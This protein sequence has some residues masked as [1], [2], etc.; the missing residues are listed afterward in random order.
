MGKDGDHICVIDT[1]RISEKVVADNGYTPDP[2][3]RMS[4]GIRTPDGG[5]GDS[6]SWTTSQLSGTSG[7]SFKWRITNQN[8]IMNIVHDKIVVLDSNDLSCDDL[9]SK[10]AAFPYVFYD[11]GG[12]LQQVKA[13]HGV[14]SLPNSQDQEP[15]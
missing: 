3:E 7:G 2:M 8:K 9:D 14:V 4:I 12:M 10:I 1:T 15:R 5:I 13:R 11:N 6:V